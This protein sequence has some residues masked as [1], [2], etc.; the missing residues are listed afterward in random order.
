MKTRRQVKFQGAPHREPLQKAVHPQDT[1][2]IDLMQ[3]P[4]LVSHVDDTSKQRY[5]ILPSTKNVVTSMVQ[6]VFPVIDHLAF[7]PTHLN[8]YNDELN[9]DNELSWPEKIGLRTTSNKPI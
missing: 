4:S 5:R 6:E 2:R 8:T 1:I 7:S 3:N 9:P